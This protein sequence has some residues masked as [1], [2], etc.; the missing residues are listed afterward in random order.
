MSTNT[1]IKN[2]LVPV[3]FSELS[4]NAIVTAVSMCK[5]HEATLHIL[6]VVENRFLIA[7]PEANMAAIYVIPELEKTGAENL[8]ELEKKIKT[9]HIVNII[10]HLEFGNPPDEI[11]DKAISISADLIVMGTHGASGMREFFIGSNAYNVIKNTTIPVLTIPGN[12]KVRDF[13][14]ILFPIRATKGIMDKYDFIEPIIE[15][16]NAELI[17]VGLSLIGEIDTPYDKNS[18]IKEFSKKLKLTDTAFTSQYFVCNNYAKKVLEV[19]K[20]EK[21]DLIVINASLD[22]KWR[23]FFVGP[24][25]QQVV[26]HSKVPVLSIRSMNAASAFAE[27]VKEEIRNAHSLQLAM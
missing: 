17:I 24:Y 10:T 23:Q 4:A 20:K 6:H 13:K 12:K 18:E 26:N 2:I 21:V 8:S 5:R 11:R 15:K 7:P 22:Y 19:A 3:D 25:T 16:N 9:K 27:A 14:K 1:T